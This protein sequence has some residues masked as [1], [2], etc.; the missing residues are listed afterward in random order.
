LR[1][2]FVERVQLSKSYAGEARQLLLQQQQQQVVK[3]VGMAA[4]WPAGWLD[5]RVQLSKG[6]AGAREAQLA[7]AAAGAN[8]SC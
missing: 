8:S 7:A 5:E 6:Y 2:C 1:C 4:S 3:V